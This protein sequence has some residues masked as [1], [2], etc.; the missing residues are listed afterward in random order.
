M[1][2]TLLLQKINRVVA[3]VLN[4]AI[5]EYGISGSQYFILATLVSKTQ[6]FFTRG[7]LAR[8]LKCDPSTLSR[9]LKVIKKNGWVN[10]E[11]NPSD[12]RFFPILITAKGRKKFEQTIG[13]VEKINDALSDE[14]RDQTWKD[15]E[16][17]LNTVSEMVKRRYEDG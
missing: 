14:L 5:S 16:R 3:T 4:Q 7:E 8:T 12:K 15:L 6:G 13:V 9:N 1:S 10:I 2:Y 11:N 17:F